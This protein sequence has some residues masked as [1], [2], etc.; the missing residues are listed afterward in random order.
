MI[1]APAPAPLVKRVLTAALAAGL[2]VIAVAWLIA[3]HKTPVTAPD[4]AA[5]KLAAEVPERDS[6]DFVRW[7][8]VVVPLSALALVVMVYIIAAAVL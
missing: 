7:I 8:P 6:E 2:V 3:A 1:A 5:E 4:A